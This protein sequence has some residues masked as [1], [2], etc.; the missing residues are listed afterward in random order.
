MYGSAKRISYGIRNAVSIGLNFR[1]LDKPVEITAA[2]GKV[3]FATTDIPISKS[4]L[5][6]LVLAWQLDSFYFVARRE[7]A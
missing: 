3:L 6:L 5:L 1:L 7:L 2:Q 4:A